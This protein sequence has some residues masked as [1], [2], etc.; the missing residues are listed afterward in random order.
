VA[1]TNAADGGIPAIGTAFFYFVTAE[2]LLDE[3][4]TKGLDSLGHERPNSSPCP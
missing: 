2:N 4:G 3:E 1:A